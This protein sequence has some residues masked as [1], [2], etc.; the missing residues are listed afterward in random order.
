MVS[1]G[2]SAMSADKVRDRASKKTPPRE[3][4]AAAALAVRVALASPTPASNLRS[5]M[6]TARQA[7]SRRHMGL[8][9]VGGGGRGGDDSSDSSSSDSED[10]GGEGGAEAAVATQEA[11]VAE[12]A[13]VLERRRFDD[14]PSRRAEGDGLVFAEFLWAVWNLASVRARSCKQSAMSRPREIVQ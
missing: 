2:L 8:G 4:L 11:V 12:A 5:E 10:E 7:M 1:K 6:R 13:R 3:K 14:R 9:G